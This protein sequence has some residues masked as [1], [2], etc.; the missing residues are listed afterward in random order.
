M[1]NSELVHLWA[2]Q[3]KS[4]GRTGTGNCSFEGR[5][6]YSYRTEI[7]RFMSDRDDVVVYT[8]HRYSVTTTGKHQ[9]H[10]PRAISHCE[11]YAVDCEMRDI[12]DTWEEA[13]HVVFL[14]I[15]QTV[16]RNLHKLK[17]KRSVSWYFNNMRYQFLEIRNFLASYNVTV[18]EEY[19]NLVT[20]S[21][22]VWCAFTGNNYSFADCIG[23]A[24]LVSQYLGIGDK[25]KI[26]LE[27]QKKREKKKEEQERLKDAEKIA[28]WRAGTYNGQLYNLPVMLRRGKG[29]II[30]TSHGAAVP[31]FQ[32]INLVDS[33]YAGN[34]IE[35]VTI[36][37]FTVRMVTPEAVIIGCHTI[38]MSEIEALFPRN[39]SEA[40]LIPH[41]IN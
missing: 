1:K 39:E 23:N 11:S 27:R 35:G 8:T 4:H 12:P 32:A 15:L 10:I 34:K 26:K 22:D 2:Q 18:P 13:K 30:E 38:P 37:N 3:T 25:L 6:L 17:T 24:E 31:L 33:L 40:R 41:V 29:G 21:E 14:D 7:A 20:L 5:S 36:G 9:I 16:N 28:E 19:K